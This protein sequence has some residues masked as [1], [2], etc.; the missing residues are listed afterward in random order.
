[1]PFIV[2]GLERF[3]GLLIVGFVSYGNRSDV[4]MVSLFLL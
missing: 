1:M 4:V 3:A 2:R